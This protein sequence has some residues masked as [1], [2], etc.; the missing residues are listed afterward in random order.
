M[1][2]NVFGPVLPSPEGYNGMAVDDDDDADATSVAIELEDDNIDQLS[3]YSAHTKQ[4]ALT[5]SSSTYSQP[6]G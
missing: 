1:E 5:Y 4:V 3:E 6:N 2:Y